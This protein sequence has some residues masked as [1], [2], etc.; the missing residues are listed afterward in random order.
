M[1]VNKGLMELFCDCVEKLFIKP[2]DRSFHRDIVHV[3]DGRARV[4]CC[5]TA[6]MGENVEQRHHVSIKYMMSSSGV[7]W[8]LSDGHVAENQISF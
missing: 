2:K 6:K 4:L 3:C 1:A 5:C 7:D 8:I